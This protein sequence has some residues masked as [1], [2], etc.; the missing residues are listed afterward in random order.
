MVDRQL[1]L[2]SQNSDFSV[3]RTELSFKNLTLGRLDYY[4]S[5]E[6][7]DKYDFVFISQHDGNI[8]EFLKQYPFLIE[9]FGGDEEFLRNYSEIDRDSGS[10]SLVNYIASKLA[11]QGFKVATLI[12]ENVP[13]AIV[14]TNVEKPRS[15]RAQSL[16]R[17]G[18]FV[19]EQNDF[20][21]IY[22]LLTTEYLKL[23]AKAKV[24]GDFHTLEPL[25]NTEEVI[26]RPENLEDFQNWFAAQINAKEQRDGCFL[27]FDGKE[28]FG[29]QALEDLIQT[30]LE[31]AGVILGKE[32]PY[33]GRAFLIRLTTAKLAKVV[34]ENG[35]IFF[36]FDMSKDAIG[37]YIRR[38]LQ[39]V[40]FE[41]EE[42]KNQNVGDA[43]VEALEERL[44]I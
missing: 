7:T 2:R 29:D 17:E 23:A 37:R 3:Q 20:G 32:G 8:D 9:M 24:F 39:K 4:N 16:I 18:E 11:E 38:D 27:S 41:V 35:G 5:D 43:I 30:R 13:R 22:D 33:N 28:Y 14:D 44:K 1:E 19:N 6:N 12:V 25:A 42:E 15:N 26:D 21:E 10:S 36:A 34:R 31:A 40:L